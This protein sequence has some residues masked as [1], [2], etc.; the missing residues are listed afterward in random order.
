MECETHED[1]IRPPLAW[2]IPTPPLN[3][4]IR[5][6]TNQESEASPALRW[7]DSYY[8][9]E[10]LR[11]IEKWHEERGITSS[12]SKMMSCPSYL[13]I[14]GM[15][16]RAVP[17]IIFQL[18]REGRRPDHWFVALKAITGEDP[19]PEE[20]RGNA[21]LMAQAWLNWA[22]KNGIW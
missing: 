7:D 19:I 13:R 22:D 14:I 10:F 20:S 21:V 8:L 4:E 9:R 3:E 2:A 1:F 17:L 5:P 18:Q 15:G 12:F 16:P 11:L 6:E